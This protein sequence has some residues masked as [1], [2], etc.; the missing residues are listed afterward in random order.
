MNLVVLNTDLPTLLPFIRF[1]KECMFYLFNDI[2]IY[3][4]PM[5]M[6]YYQ[7]KGTIALGPSWIRDLKVS[8]DFEKRLKSYVI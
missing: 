6:G 5:P 7:H 4:Y 2:L 1:I 8:F 3:T